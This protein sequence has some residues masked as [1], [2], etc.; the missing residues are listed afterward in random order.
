MT[1]LKK[2]GAQPENKNS[3]KDSDE[4]SESHLNIRCNILDK[5]AWK[6]AAEAEQ[7]TLS[8]WIIKTL[9]NAI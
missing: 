4:K 3:V 6:F 8:K 9:N 7:L 1:N 5:S 2:P